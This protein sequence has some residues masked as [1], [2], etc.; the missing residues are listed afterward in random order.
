[1]RLSEG[2]LGEGP[3]ATSGW[4]GHVDPG[5]DAP[6]LAGR[7]GTEPAPPGFLWGGPKCS[8][9]GL[10]WAGEAGLARAR[11]LRPLTAWLS[12]LKFS[13]RHARQGSLVASATLL[14]LAS[15]PLGLPLGISKTCF[16][17]F[18][19][20]FQTELFLSLPMAE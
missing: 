8:F 10:A 18:P 17:F 4:R 7:F 6:P 1:M 12:L 20:V 13:M 9:P 3:P 14:P 5:E 19:P 15:S 16:F 11:R 2:G